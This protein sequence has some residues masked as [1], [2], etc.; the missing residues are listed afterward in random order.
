[1]LHVKRG[2]TKVLLVL[3]H[4]IEYALRILV[5]VTVVIL[6][7]LVPIALFI[8]QIFVRLAQSILLKL[9]MDLVLDVE[10]RVEWIRRQIYRVLKTRV[11][12][13]ME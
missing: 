7:L 3:L 13:R 10:R 9:M 4:L 12:V 6:Q 5:H 2:L 1:M 8:S 11:F